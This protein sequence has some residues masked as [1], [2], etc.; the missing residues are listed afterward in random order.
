MSHESPVVEQ[1]LRV[2]I[3]SFYLFYW[4][5]YLYLSSPRFQ[6]I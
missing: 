1:P 2:L 4:L 5:S 3:V 6:V